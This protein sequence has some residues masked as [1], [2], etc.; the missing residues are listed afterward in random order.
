MPPSLGMVLVMGD[1]VHSPVLTSPRTFLQPQG[2]LFRIGGTDPMGRHSQRSWAMAWSSSSPRGPQQ[3]C[4]VWFSSLRAACDCSGLAKGLGTADPQLCRLEVPTHFF[5][6]MRLIR[7]IFCGSSHG[8]P[9]HPGGL[10]AGKGFGVVS[11][12]ILAFQ[13]STSQ[14]RRVAL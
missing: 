10:G 3:H 2:H 4:S 12:M 11:H 6:G 7:S 14:C 5:P 9:H 13:V 1:S 8:I